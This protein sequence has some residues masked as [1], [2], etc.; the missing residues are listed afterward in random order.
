M[1][2]SKKRG[3][4]RDPGQM[5]IRANRPRV[6]V[7]QGE[8]RLGQTKFRANGPGFDKYNEFGSELR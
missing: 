4:Q 2:W 5:L 6:K 3:G 1:C 8:N 7:N